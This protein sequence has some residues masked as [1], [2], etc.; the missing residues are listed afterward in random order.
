MLLGLFRLLGCLGPGAVPFARQFGPGNG[1]L[2]FVEAFLADA[3]GGGRVEALLH[4]LFERHPLALEMYA[5]APRANT[6]ETF[7]ILNTRE[8]AMCGPAHEEP[9]GE[10]QQHVQC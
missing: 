9:D 4:E 5:A 2:L 8:N 7:Q 6:H 3:V 10:Y 1:D